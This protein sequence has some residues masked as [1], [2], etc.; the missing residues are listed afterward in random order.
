MLESVKGKDG[1]WRLRFY[2]TGRYKTDPTTN[3]E[4]AYATKKEAEY[5][6][7]RLERAYTDVP[8]AESDHYYWKA[9]HKS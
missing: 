1:K 9:T 5:W 7:R 2:Q 3:E 4:L 8:R 6:R